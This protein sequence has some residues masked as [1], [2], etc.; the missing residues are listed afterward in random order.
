MW[1][2][3]VCGSCLLY[4]EVQVL[5]TGFKKANELN[6]R[7]ARKVCCRVQLV[8]AFSRRRKVRRFGDFRELIHFS[9]GY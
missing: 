7:S 6:Q 4:R 1:Q 2:K 3:D 5:V 8:H 9:D